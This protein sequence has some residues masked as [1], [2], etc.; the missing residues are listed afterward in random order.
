MAIEQL[1]SNLEVPACTWDH[2][3]PEVLEQAVTARLQHLIQDKQALELLH[4]AAFTALTT[5]NQLIA[6]LA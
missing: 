1:L 5:A 2:A 3:F 4:M 6:R